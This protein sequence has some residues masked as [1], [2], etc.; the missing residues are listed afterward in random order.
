[1]RQHLSAAVN[2]SFPG[3]KSKRISFPGTK[4][5]IMLRLRAMRDYLS[6]SGNRNFYN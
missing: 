6:G 5:Q 4:Q 1:M 3:C 2:D